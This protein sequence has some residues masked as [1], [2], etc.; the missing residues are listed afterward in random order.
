MYK[1][2]KY[3]NTSN[4]IPEKSTQNLKKKMYTYINDIIVV[5]GFYETY[6]RINTYEYSSVVTR[7][8]KRAFLCTDV[9]SPPTACYGRS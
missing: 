1:F 4:V 2:V 8:D 3:F 7:L 5:F 6:R 9:V